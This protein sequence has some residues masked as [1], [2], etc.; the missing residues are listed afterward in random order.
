[1][2][3]LG[4][5]GT[6]EING[7]RAEFGTTGYTMDHVFVLY[8]RASDSV[9]Y[10][11]EANL[12]A[13][14][15]DLRGQTIEFVDKPAPIA[16]GEW[17][18]ANP[19]STILLPSEWDFRMLNRPYLGIGLEDGDD[20]VVITEVGEDTPAFE[21]GFEAG[22]I[23][24]RIGEHIVEKRRDIRE[25]MAAFDAGEKV[26]VVVERNG[27]KKTLKPTLRKRSS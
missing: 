12:V 6:R 1:M 8:D 25:I 3:Q 16:L 17:L 14:A 13:V 7:R 4:A 26:K 11:D 24:L 21:A 10:P 20:G 23:L 19:D 15:G 18:D 22:D 5:V 9:W 2:A 27:R